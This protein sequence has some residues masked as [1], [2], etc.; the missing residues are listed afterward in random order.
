[1]AIRK[2]RIDEDPVLRK[3]AKEIKSIDDST[4]ELI[5]DMAETMY[6][7]PGVGLAAPQV[8]VSKRLVMV[9]VDDG[10]GLQ[11]F[12]NPRIIKIEGDPEVGPEGCLS[13]PGIYG[14]VERCLKI[15][16]KGL[17]RKG[18]GITVEASGFRA[19]AIQHEIDHLEGIL[20]TD[21]A[22]NLRKIADEPEEEDIKDNLTSIV[23]EIKKD[24]LKDLSA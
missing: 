4:K 21:K 5:D 14:D 22:S 20:F 7:A 2:I 6:D 17:N 16:V 8:G 9:D 10:Q 15:T 19:R 24:K 11:V 23:E 1:M 3:K 12:V 13:V 18:K